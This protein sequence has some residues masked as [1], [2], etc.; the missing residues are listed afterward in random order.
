M[1]PFR[2]PLV[3]GVGTKPLVPEGLNFSSKNYRLVFILSTIY[4]YM[5]LKIGWHLKT[6]IDTNSSTDFEKLH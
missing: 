2:P 4:R 3:L 1:G 5:Y 6:Y